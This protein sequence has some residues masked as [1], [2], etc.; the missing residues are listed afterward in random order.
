MKIKNVYF[1]IK[2]L[3][4]DC[5]CHIVLINHWYYALLVI[6]ICLDKWF[7]I[8]VYVMIILMAIFMRNVVIVECKG[9]SPL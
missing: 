6:I 1:S 4:T 8:C 5:L 2:Y 3:V 7:S 9:G